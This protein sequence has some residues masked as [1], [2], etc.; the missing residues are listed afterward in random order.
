MSF[1]SSLLNAALF[2]LVGLEVV[3][4]VV[5]LGGAG[6][7]H[8]L[9][10][11]AAGSAAVI[12]ARFAWLFTSPYLIRALDRRP[13]QRRLRLGARPRAVM[14]AAGFR[15]AVSL[16]AA[17]AVPEAIGS[18][19]PFPDRD[20]IVFVT[21]GVIAVTLLLQ[22]P[23]LPVVVRWARLRGDEDAV[24]RE[25]RRAEITALQDAL[26]ALP[27]LAEDLGTDQE[28]ADQLRGEYDRR[29][30]ILSANERDEPPAEGAVSREKQ[31]VDLRVALLGRKH[32]TLV[33]LWDQDEID[34]SVLQHVQA[35]FD[36][37]R[38][39]VEKHRDIT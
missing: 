10:V 35:V 14:A 13:Q 39:S 12:G 18:G 15:G 6:L 28:V 17:L 11:A 3:S 36:L 30:Q 4:A 20:L 37:E 22:A 8:G 24:E 29:L 26:E 9:V 33:R 2:V 34:D 27:G 5:N 25:R 19:E 38:V 32:D 21:A 16:A 1:I 7:A 23:L 31:H